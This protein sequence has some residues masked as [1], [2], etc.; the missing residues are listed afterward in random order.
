VLVAGALA[1]APAS[2]YRRAR[3]PIAAARFLKALLQPAGH[4]LGEE[5]GGGGALLVEAAALAPPPLMFMKLLAH[6]GHSPTNARTSPGTGSR[7][8][9]SS[10]NGA[11]TGRGSGGAT[12]GAA[13]LSFASSV[14]TR[15]LSSVSEVTF[16]DSEMSFSTRELSC[17][18]S[19]MTFSC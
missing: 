8:G 6:S 3:L 11:G 4:S 2:A 18:V 10:A 5:E 16:S 12:G 17:P 19:E 1:P 13:A 14:S 7:N 15:C 9:A